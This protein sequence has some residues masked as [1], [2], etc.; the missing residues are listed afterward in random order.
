MNKLKALNLLPIQHYFQ[1]KKLRLF[2]RIRKDSIGIDMPDYVVQHRL[3]TYASNNRHKLSVTTNI[4]QPIV[5]PFGNS[6]YP[7]TIAIWNSLPNSIYVIDSVNECIKLKNI[8][9]LI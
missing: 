9:G 6:F 8:Y 3:A 5:R 7:S 4:I 2:Y 1:L